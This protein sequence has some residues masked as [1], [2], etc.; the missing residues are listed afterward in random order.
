MKTLTVLSIVATLLSSM[1]TLWS[2]HHAQKRS[3]NE[4]RVSVSKVVGKV[5]GKKGSLK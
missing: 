2:N 1:S 4:R 5:S 3:F